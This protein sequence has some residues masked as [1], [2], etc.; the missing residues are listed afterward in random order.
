[1]SSD[2]EPK[3]IRQQQLRQQAE[4]KLK[5]IKQVIQQGTSIDTLLHEL[6]VHQIE[7]EMQNESLRQ[8]LLA[9]EIS[10]DRYVDLYEF[11]PISYITLNVDGLI[12]EINLT[13]AKLLGKE[14]K[15]LL[16]RHFNQF[17]IDPDQECWHHF[18]INLIKG[19]H[20]QKQFIELQLKP[21]QNE[22]V[23][24]RLECLRRINDA[25]ENE[26]RLAIIDIT[27][28]K[29]AETDLKIAAV[30]FESL[31]AMMVTDAN[32]VTLKV[33]NAFTQMTGY[34]AS[35]L[36]GKTPRV[37]KSGRH[38]ADFYKK[39]WL[40]INTTGSW[41]GEIWDKRKNT[42]LFP[43]WLTITAVTNEENI[44][45]HYVAIH[46]DIAHR[47]EAANEIER[48]AFYD[49]LTELPNRRLLLERLQQAL[50]SSSRRH[51]FGGLLF[52]DLDNFKNLN[53][54]LGHDM[55]DQLLQQVGKRLLSCVR[56]DDTVARL[57]GDE[58][59]VMMENLSEE[60]S[61][62]VIQARMIGEKILANLNQTFLIQ[63]REYRNTC[64]IGAV[65]FYNHDN[66]PQELLKRADI[67]MYQAKGH[68]R[69]TLRFFDPAMQTILD[70]RAQIIQDLRTALADNQFQLYYQIQVSGKDIAVGAEAL[71]R[72][73]HPTKGLL[74]PYDF[75]VLAEESIE[76]CE[77]GQWVMNTA[78]QQLKK[79]KNSPISE[80]LNLSVNVS[81]KQFH[82]ADF[83]SQV[84]SA[85]EHAGVEPSKLKLEL[86]E[87]LVLDDI[88]DTIIKMKT[89]RK[90]GVLFSMDDFGTGYSS[91]SYLTQLPLDQLKIDR[92]FVTNI[93]DNASDAVIVKT[94]IGMTKNLNIQVIAEGVETE[95]QR[96]KLEE[97]GCLHYQGYLFSQPLPID[98][99]EQLLL[100]MQ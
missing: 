44:V 41:Q 76:I 52:I 15:Q 58:F 33:N 62:A 80:Y 95:L 94:I 43:K 51:L 75:I 92:S 97:Y 9:L 26:V 81:A 10:R 11:S 42:E 36:I 93:S 96:A 14:R 64:S 7:L 98:A 53:D 59:V 30:A 31:E 37:L 87:T 6:Q 40:S 27:E 63:D 3:R 13:G 68:G 23:Y 48:L 86:T 72:W 2:T 90:F 69:N 34:A 60:L 18:Y 78:C 16:Q 65:L 46:T 50:A 45:T 99:F 24:V 71:I 21:F 85:I 79:W 73:Q 25:G 82:Q 39:I 66:T 5:G 17:F 88:V 4:E 22:V 38:D 29:Q 8:A 56:E 57:G 89:L 91:L 67:A 47:K 61:Q 49:S 100:K 32:L 70:N 19:K 35:E 55:G 84:M 20:L 74:Q 54:S 28:I 12:T 83:V 77:I 1:M